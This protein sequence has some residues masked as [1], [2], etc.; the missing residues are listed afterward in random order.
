MR[1][2]IVILG[3]LYWAPLI[4]QENDSLI[5]SKI[6]KSNSIDNIHLK[7]LTDNGVSLKKNEIVNDIS[8]L[9]GIGLR[10][11][12]PS[13]TYVIDIFHPFSN[14]T[15]S[16]FKWMLCQWSSRF[17]LKGAKPKNDENNSYLYSDS[18]KKFIIH[19][20]S[21]T[22]EVTMELCASEE[23]LH[24][25]ENGEFWPHLLLEQ[26]FDKRYSLSKLKNLFFNIDTKLIYAE[27]HMKSAQFNP[28]LHT[29][30]FVSYLVIVNTNSA[31]KG[32][33]NCFYFGINLF[34]YR[35][36]DIP[37]YASADVGKNDATGNY[38]F[39]PA[40]K[41][42]YKGSLHDKE[43]IILHKNILPLLK[44][45]FEQAKL[46]GFLKHTSFED[47]QL[48]GLNIGW[49]MPGTINA[50]IIWKNLSILGE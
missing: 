49:E 13:T 3:I 23:Y 50:E 35:Y 29:A 34:D 5:Q 48:A 8:F 36:R 27:N 20:L 18:S 33:N 41:E 24:P 26:N 11:T 15:D 4:G 38:I 45:A 42:L 17:N 2:I 12:L 47:L 19:A 16:G 28:G 46:S 31:S 43:W 40:A 14:K 25:R 30:Q 37:F 39:C 6:L 32:Y 44:K 22:I 7:I 1:Q 9:K 21:K 10:D